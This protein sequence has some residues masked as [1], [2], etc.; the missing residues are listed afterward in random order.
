MKDVDINDL[1]KEEKDHFDFKEYSDDDTHALR[2]LKIAS[3]NKLFW[4][5]VEQIGIPKNGR[6]EYYIYNYFTGKSKNIGISYI[7]NSRENLQPAKWF[8]NINEELPERI[9][10]NPIY[11]EK[12]L[13]YKE[14]VGHIKLLDLMKDYTIQQFVDKYDLNFYQ[15][16]NLIYKKVDKK[17]NK[18][19]F[20]ALPS[21]SLII[22]LRNIINPDYWFIF[23]EELI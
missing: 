19:V 2:A 18:E 6:Y 3:K 17:L 21:N 13:L 1:I 11:E 23:P 12:T 4:K 22:K 16:K 9:K 10:F 15:I 8:F 20:K 14:S 7:F 5:Y